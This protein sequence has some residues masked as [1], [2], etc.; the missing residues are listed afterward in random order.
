MSRTDL[1]ALVGSA[2]PRIATPP[3][4]ELTPETSEGFAVI[5]YARDV[6][7]MPLLPWQET[8]AI[9]GLELLPDGRP[10]FRIL[11]LLIARQQGK[12]ELLTV[13]CAYWMF[14]LSLAVILGTST[15]IS[16]A[17]EPW[18][19]MIRLVNRTEALDEFHEPGR[20]WVRNTNGEQECWTI[21]EESRYLISAANEEGGRGLTLDRAVIDEL[22]Q[23]H[24]RDAWEAA[25]PAASHPHSQI[26]ALSNAGSARSVVLN[27]LRA[28]ALEFI[29]NGIGDER[30]G[31]LEWS[32]P[33]GSDPE[34]VSALLQ[35]NPRVGHGYSLADLLGKAR[36]AKRR[37]GRSLS[38]F[39]TEYMCLQVG[40][41]DPAI[42]Y[43]DWLAAGEPGDLSEVRSRVAMVVDV[44]PDMEHVSAYAAALLDDGRVRVDHVAS[45]SGARAVD[46]MR[47]EI[48]GWVHRVKPSVLGWFP[49]SGA[50][51][52]ADLKDRRKAGRLGWPPPG[53][54]IEEIRTEI[55]AV[56]VGF[57]EQVKARRIVHNGQD[58]LLNAQV[59][60]AEKVKKP[61]GGFVFAPP[62]P[63]NGS[64]G[65]PVHADALY[66]AA[67]AAHLARVLPVKRKPGRMIG[68]SV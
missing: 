62:P 15:K 21:G 46:E 50:V 44:S 7:N 51:L 8:A 23:H 10:R 6:L 39:L 42:D 36:G 18:R 26:W 56:C 55:T 19:K 4:R 40:S 60:V 64:S 67:G 52:A 41:M 34:D 30:L 17:R 37:G 16:T 68:S 48:R 43:A 38:G 5:A 27:D 3:L 63:V 31:I 9:R 45:W 59:E 49:S 61:G 20:K 65:P 28:D 66:A 32:A 25:E 29:E 11:L 47:H 24:T 13:L 35:A 58:M 1:S 54:T 14:K 33:E 53:V 22:R 2:E 12:T 57:T